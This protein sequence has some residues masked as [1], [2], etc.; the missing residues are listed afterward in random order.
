MAPGAWSYGFVIPDEAGCHRHSALTSA[1]ALRLVF[2]LRGCLK[3][4]IRLVVWLR[5][6]SEHPVA[7]GHLARRK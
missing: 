3:T 1:S 5:H 7:T 4:Q 2:V 6:S